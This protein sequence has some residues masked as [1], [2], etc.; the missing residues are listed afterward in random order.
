[1]K[2]KNFEKRMIRD[3]LPIFKE[4]LSKGIS[5]S[6][7]KKAEKIYLEYL[8]VSLIIEISEET[9]RMHGILVDIA[10]YGKTGLHPNK[11]LIKEFVKKHEGS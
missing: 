2:A 7:R 1:M 5:K 9:D 10:Y 4:Y 3:M 6:L 8:G 11:T